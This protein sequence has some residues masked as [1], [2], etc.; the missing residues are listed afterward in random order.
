M[1]GLSIRSLRVFDAIILQGTLGAAAEKLNMSQSA[2]SR[3][4]LELERDLGLSLFTRT[5]RHLQPTEEGLRFHH[6][7]QHILAGINEIPNIVESIKADTDEAISIIS[8]PRLSLG[9]LAPA[10]A[11]LAKSHPT[12]KIKASVLRRYDIQRWAATRE[13]DIGLG[14]L[15]LQHQALKEFP[16][17]DVRA[18]ALVPATHPIAGQAEVTIEQLAKLPVITYQPGL[19]VH[20]QM[21]DLCRSAGVTLNSVAEVSSTLLANQLAVEGAGIA[22]IDVASAHHYLK[23]GNL[24]LI[25]I[26]PTRWWR[27][28]LFALRASDLTPHFSLLETTFNAFA[29]QLRGN[30]P[31][32]ELVRL[33]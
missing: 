6:E 5:N 1:A 20:Q 25:P 22:I 33:V 16:L 21:D 10:M 4:L 26:S 29:K 19:M 3:Q 7:S 24:E 27:I 31:G 23:S 30:E 8:M 14:M 12:L 28:G 13:F 2:A 9:L 18:C 17:F 11:I 32:K 15:P